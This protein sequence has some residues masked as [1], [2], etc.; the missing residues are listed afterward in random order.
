MSEPTLPDA[1]ESAP[2]KPSALRWAVIAVVVYTAVASLLLIGGRANPAVV[3]HFGRKAPNL[4]LA[5]SDFGPS[6]PIPLKDGQDG[7]Y[8][9]VLARDPLLL[10]PATV[11]RNLDRPAYRAQ[12]IGYPAL[13]APWGVAGPYGLAWGLIITNLAAVA[14]GAAATAGIAGRRGVPDRA[15]LAWVAS[16][17]IFISFVLDTGDVV[18]LAAV[19]VCVWSVLARR[20]G[21]AVVTAVVATLAREPSL[22]AVGA[23]AVASREMPVRWRRL[24]VLC[25][26]LAGA[27]WALYERWRLSWPAARIED[28]SAPLGGYDYAFRHGWLPFHDWGNAAVAVAVLLFAIYTVV[29]WMKHRQDLLL[30]AALPYVVLVPV[31]SGQVLDLSTNSLRAIGAAPTLVWLAWTSYHTVSHVPTAD[32]TATERRPPATAAGAQGA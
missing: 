20:W 16:P 8:F 32:R 13:A 2:P 29:F 5:R 24:L 21:A 30:W 17:A 19:M 4:A 27:A 12:R 9:W 26:A 11:F 1:R 31:F 6:V 23:L 18:A 10:H 15:V 7:E 22:L 25:P 3:I 14:V 28:F